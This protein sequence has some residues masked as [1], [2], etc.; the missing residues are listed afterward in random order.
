[1]ADVVVGE[2]R[3]GLGTR[4][5][6]PRGRLG[7]KRR[8]VYTL[9]LLP[10]VVL[11][12]GLVAYPVFTAFINSLESGNTFNEET[13]HFV[14]LANY[15]TFFADP[16]AAQII[17]N[18]F[19]RAIGGVVPSYLLG[20]VAALALNRVTRGRGVIQV[21]VL[22]PFVISGAVSIAA[23]KLILDPL[24]GILPAFG[25][26][27]QDLFVSTT[28]VWPT[29]LFMNA[30]GSFQFYSIVFLAT[31]Q[32]VPAELYEAAQVDGA[33]AF[34]RF[35]AVTLPALG[36]VSAAV[37]A[38]HFLGSFQEFNLVYIATGGGPLNTTQT[39]ATYSYQV[40]FGGSYDLGYASAITF[41]SAAFMAV[42]LAAAAVIYLVVRRTRDRW[43]T[44]TLERWLSS[45]ARYVHVQSPSRSRAARRTRRRRRAPRWARGIGGW[46]GVLLLIL[47]SLF[48]VLFLVSRSF[49][50]A[51]PT[52]GLT[53]FPKQFTL[54]NWDG[55]FKSSFLFVGTSSSPPLIQNLANSV[56][57]VAAVT[58]I[59][60]V[61]SVFGGYGLARVGAR[62]GTAATGLL[63][64]TQLIPSIILVFPIYI[65][66]AEFKLLN[67]AGLIIATSI[68]FVPMATLFFQAYFRG[69]GMELEEAAALDGAGPVR[70]FLSIILP[71]AR[72][73]IGAMT[74]FILISAWN[75]Y[76]FALT[77]IIDAGQRTFPPALAN[78]TSGFEFLSEAG[79]GGQA[80][81]LL[82]PI[83]LSAILLSFTLKSFTTA[84]AGG[85]T[86]G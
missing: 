40:G 11:V 32:R 58:L 76:L 56:I 75:E 37:C 2:R 3:V 80:V 18:S 55:A 24:T 54:D 48:P 19:I 81:Y 77:L 60:L 86:K 51:P 23:W 10:S 15:V 46:I 72:S 61:V 33:G 82:I 38:L 68:M 4:G 59:A 8:T 66:A 6:T 1:V 53:L 42:S 25:L 74:A 52:G 64:A 13:S 63:L 34:Q 71:L 69:I 43:Q 14:G 79:P 5:G 57:V 12:V 35:R 17:G 49:D 84:V 45:G 29:L 30:W 65:M 27:G 47:F 44:A 21:L 22:L 83:I 20:L 41:I 28:W 78:F 62:R 16:A 39:M 36:G 73:S 70:T 85:G 67:Q 9:F 50:A 31:L 26:A 7:R